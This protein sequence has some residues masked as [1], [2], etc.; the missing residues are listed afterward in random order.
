MI[1]VTTWR[2][3]SRWFIVFVLLAASVGCDGA[4]R[5][6]GTGDADPSADMMDVAGGTDT[7]RDA[8]RDGRTEEDGRVELPDVSLEC[9]EICSLLQNCGFELEG[10]ECF[11]QCE[12]RTFEACLL[13]CLEEP[14]DSCQRARRC[15][16]TCTEM[17]AG[18]TG[19]GG[20]S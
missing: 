2:Q 1:E 4:G 13:E 18:M 6:E 8:G 3:P 9:D 17:D 10:D 15:Q 12:Q 7:V 14:T 19:D 11:S 20:G 16:L 5:G